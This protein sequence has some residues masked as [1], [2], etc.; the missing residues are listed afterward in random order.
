MT[1]SVMLKPGS[2]WLRG[3][4]V[5]HVSRVWFCIKGPRSRHVYTGAW[6]TTLG[7]LLP[8]Q[9]V[10]ASYT[11]GV[12]NMVPPGQDC[13]STAHW[14]VSKI[15]FYTICLFSFEWRHTWKEHAFVGCAA[16]L[17]IWVAPQKNGT[18]LLCRVK[19]LIQLLLL[20]LFL[21]FWYK[22]AAN[23]GTLTCGGTFCSVTSPV[24]WCRVE[25]KRLAISGG[26]LNAERWDGMRF[27]NHWQSHISTFVYV[28]FL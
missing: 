4:K 25:K 7:P 8:I 17:S 1:Q 26:N 23:E 28:L 22:G 13:Y 9:H 24:W 15:Q 2:C 11:P 16:E 27:C 6:H 5:C 10:K 14:A 18:N 12:T 21:S 3:Q 19:Q 20:T